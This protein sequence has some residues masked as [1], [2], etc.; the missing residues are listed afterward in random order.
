MENWLKE[1]DRTSYLIGIGIGIL[2]LELLGM[3]VSLI[4][5]CGIRR[6]VQFKV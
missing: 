3:I 6:V 1:S 2:V 5:C 4:L